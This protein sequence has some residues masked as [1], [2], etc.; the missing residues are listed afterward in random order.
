MVA[1]GDSAQN[2]LVN[3]PAPCGKHILENSHI[4]TDNAAIIIAAE[5]ADDE[6]NIEDEF[7]RNWP[8]IEFDQSDS[9]YVD[10]PYIEMNAPAA[11]TVQRNV[12]D[13]DDDDISQLEEIV[14]DERG[15]DH[16]E[17]EGT[18]H[19]C[20]VVGQEE[21]AL[22]RRPDTPMQS[23][24]VVEPVALNDDQNNMT[25]GSDEYQGWAPVGGIMVP[26][27]EPP[28]V[29]N[30]VLI[31][32]A[33]FNALPAALSTHRFGPP[34][35]FQPGSSPAATLTKSLTA[36]DFD[37]DPEIGVSSG[38]VSRERVLGNFGVDNLLFAQQKL[39]IEDD[40]PSGDG[41]ATSPLGSAFSVESEDEPCSAD[42]PR[43]DG[44]YTPEEFHR[45]RAY[46]HARLPH[47]D[48]PTK[49]A[50]CGQNPPSSFIVCAQCEHVRYCRKYCQVW[51]WPL[52]LFVCQ[53][54][55]TAKEEEV[56]T[57]VIWAA[58]YWR[59]AITAICIALAN[60][61]RLEDC[62][63]DRIPAVEGGDDV[64]ME[65]D[66][67]QE[68]EEESQGGLARPACPSS[69]YWSRAMSL[70]L[71]QGRRFKIG[72]FDE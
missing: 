44:L 63:N 39:T 28:G 7:S 52:H 17:E 27:F 53:R 15:D 64:Q 57:L 9:D 35:G 18:S 20:F 30:R 62:P 26:Y 23:G 71:A 45:I 43:D 67:G 48:D 22:C 54:S 32:E 69:M 2:W 33:L 65:D 61:V 8:G 16:G 46:L 10:D 29:R 60:G 37:N 50:N 68:R 31:R 24:G 42:K 72:L 38:P 36:S 49:C 66:G 34:Y 58:E 14:E 4:Q 3:S 1:G 21:C 19:L 6:G 56:R 25:D 40:V 59:G 41:R 70:H 55:A 47:L 11:I 5:S 13:E 12:V 51:D